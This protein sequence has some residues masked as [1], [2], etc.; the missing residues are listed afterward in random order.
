MG[1]EADEKAR[2]DRAA[3]LHQQI[4]QMKA[5]A[6]RSQPPCA[7]EPSGGESPREYTQ[8]RMRESEAAEQDERTE[9]G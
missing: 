4:E 6:S 5:G 2:K 7:D 1:K 3:R 9:Q 8:R